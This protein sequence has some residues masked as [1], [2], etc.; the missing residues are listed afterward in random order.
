MK[1]NLLKD[2]KIVILFIFIGSPLR[3]YRRRTQFGEYRVSSR[4]LMDRVPTSSTYVSTSTK[5]GTWESSRKYHMN[6][7]SCNS[8]MRATSLPSSI[9]GRWCCFPIGNRWRVSFAI[10]PTYTVSRDNTWWSGVYNSYKTSKES[11]YFGTWSWRGSGRHFRKSIQV[12]IK[13]S[14]FSWMS[15]V[16]YPTH[17][18]NRL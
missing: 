14:K 8:M 9:W 7:H 11:T 18:V 1:D 5:S 2:Q 17:W 10:Y 4:F 6:P 3:N 13:H 16:P 15:R 12:H